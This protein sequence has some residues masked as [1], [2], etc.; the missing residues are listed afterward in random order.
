MA[1]A[2]NPT[3]DQFVNWANQGGIGKTDLVHATKTQGT[4]GDEKVTVAGNA[5]DCIGF[6]ASRRGVVCAADAQG[7]PEAN[8]R[9]PSCVVRVV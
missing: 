7:L 4:A 3:L 8:E 2:F 9:D 5:N 6:F 1:I